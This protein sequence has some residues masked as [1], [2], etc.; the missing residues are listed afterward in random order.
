MNSNNKHLIVI[1]ACLCSLLSACN[2]DS[3]YEKK[4]EKCHEKGLQRN[5][6]EHAKADKVDGILLQYELQNIDY[7]MDSIERMQYSITDTF[8][9]EKIYEGEGVY[10]IILLS[11]GK[12]KYYEVYS[13]K[14]KGAKGEKIKIE[15]AYP[16][17]IFPFFKETSN[18]PLEIVRPVYFKGYRIIPYPIFF[19]QVYVTN[20]LE[21]LYIVSFAYDF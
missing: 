5:I 13:P 20:N 16:M 8:T 6:R 11:R 9:V 18:R 4:Y 21:G 10:E 2:I 3:I 1:S 12:N 7:E 14:E 15:K 19:G 17:T